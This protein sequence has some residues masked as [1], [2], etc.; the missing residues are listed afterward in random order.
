MTSGKR[1]TL[2]YSRAP[3]G[4]EK[5]GNGVRKRWTWG[6][7]ENREGVSQ[8]EGVERERHRDRMAVRR[9]FVTISEEKRIMRSTGWLKTTI[10]RKHH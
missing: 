6:I 5:L 1:A 8:A 9:G 2:H 10:D 7:L 4:G 3:Y